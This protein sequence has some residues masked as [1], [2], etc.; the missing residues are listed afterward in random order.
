M[1]PGRNY[2]PL[3]FAA[4]AWRRRWLIAGGLAFGVYASLLVSSQLQDLFQSEMLIQVIPQ[5]VPDNYVQSTVTMRTEERLNA[6][7]QRVLSRTALE[8][9]INDMNL[10]AER[11]VRLPMEDV[12]ELM[13]KDVRVDPASGSNRLADAFYVRFTY[14]DRDVATKVTDRLGALFIDL[15]AKDRGQMAQATNDFLESQLA[16]T[17]RQLEVQERKLEVFRQRNAGR[18]PTQLESN[19]QAIQSTQLTIQAQVESLARDR[20]RKL[21]LERLLRDAE[22]ESAATPVPPRAMPPPTDKAADGG[23]SVALP[24]GQQLATLREALARLLLRLKPEHPD[25]ARAKRAIAELE[26]RVAREASEPKPAEGNATV[27]DPAPL[28]AEAAARRERQQQMRA[29]V[30]SIERQIAFKEAEEKRLRETLAMY[31]NRIEQIPGVESDWIALTRDYKTQQAAYENLLAKSEQSKV[32][33]ELERRQI[34]EQFRVLDPARP[35]VRPAGIRRMQVNGFGTAA[36]LLLGL[37]V[38]ALLEFRDRT[39]SSAQDVQEVLQLPI[40][41]HLPFVMIDAD[42]RRRRRVQMIAGLA[43]LFVAV[44]GAYGFWALRLWKFVV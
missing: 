22:V 44:V 5:R 20:D 6:L 37:A 4:M 23:P 35:P 36:G 41:A 1:L 24:A 11:R 25:V 21:M 30:E 7:S 18:L 10:Y 16:E 2:T 32:A 42:R 39:F 40:V 13:R 12:V 3:D 43:V 34:G 33:V 17:R 29:D 38:A 31:Q 27:D 9:L 14:P 19:M 26:A 15:N 28:S 8:S